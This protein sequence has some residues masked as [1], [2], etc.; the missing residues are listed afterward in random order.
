MNE[1]RVRFDP[2]EINDVGILFVVLM[3]LLAMFRFC[4][5]SRCVLHVFFIFCPQH[6]KCGLRRPAP[7]QTWRTLNLKAA[8]A[9]HLGGV[10]PS[11]M[12]PRPDEP[13][14]C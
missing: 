8:G 9:T 3:I 2:L 11:S 4:C 1:N 5:I 6:T 12:A 7:P 13:E 10:L 14:A